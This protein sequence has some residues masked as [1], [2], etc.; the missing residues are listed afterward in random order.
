MSPI[1]PNFKPGVGHL[2]TDRYDFQNHIDG[3]DFRHKAGSIDL[4][5]TIMIGSTVI[6]DVQTAIAALA[7]SIIV[8][9]VPDATTSSKGIIQLNGDLFGNGT[10]ALN[11]RVSGL[12]G[13]PV[14]VFS[15]LTTNQVLTWNGSSWINQAVPGSISIA[16][17]LAGVGS[18]L[19]VPRVGGLQG[20][21]VS[22]TTPTSGQALVW[23][24]S[25]W[26][27]TGIPT[28]PTGTGFATLTSGIYDVAATAN[29]RYTGGK[30]Q[31]SGNIQYIAAGI[32]GDLAWTPTSSN[33]TLTLPNATDT[34]VGQATTDTLTNKNLNA[35][36]NTI[37]DTSTATGDLLVSNGTKFLRFAKGGNGTFLGVSGGTLGY[38]TP[39][40]S[41]P[42]GTGFATITS[43]VYDSAASANVRYTGGKFQTDVNLQFKTAGQTG[44]LSWP[45][46]TTTRTITLPDASDT[47]VGLAT[48]D[49][50]LNKTINATNNTISDSSIATGDILKSNGSKFIRFGMGSAL[51]VL[52]VNA[53]GTDLEYANNSAGSSTGTSGT[54]QLSNGTG[55]FLA[56]TNVIGGTSFLSI[57]TTPATTGSLRFPYAATDTIVAVKDSGGTDR[58]LISRP[59]S[60]VVQ[61]GPNTTNTLALTFNGNTLNFFP[62]SQFNI[63]APSGSSSSF[64]VSG[65]GQV[66]INPNGFAGHTMDINTGAT[67]A[68]AT[69]FG[70]VTGVGTTTYSYIAIANS[71]VPPT[72]TP[73]GGG[74]LYVEAGALKY[75]GSSGTLTVIAPA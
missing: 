71:A 2:V 7:G 21:S 43:G 64:K 23:N 44:D 50:L 32:T 45:S 57:G 27:P 74:Y 63:T 5:P 36:N 46:I 31:T 62:A 15:G 30:F 34:L 25:S 55:G 42:T 10:T 19:S 12:Q 59:S 16:G 20:F 29:I 22:S 65:T 73:T 47:L 49:I 66:Q 75:R 17:D 33:R 13:T 58:E 35:T 3:V 53:A 68:I 37:T 51:Q 4:H 1:N 39:S 9:S 40:S 18:T 72:G 67:G 11:P 56:A 38:Y 6:T 26:T 70:G 8:P 61:F 54:V 69:F 48:T 14:S 60:N 52:R 41:T 28:S 24:G